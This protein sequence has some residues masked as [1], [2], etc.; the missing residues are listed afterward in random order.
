M[1]LSQSERSG[2]FF[3]PIDSA[4]GTGAGF[5]VLAGGNVEQG[6]MEQ[7]PRSDCLKSYTAIQACCFFCDLAG[8]SN[9]GR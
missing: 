7:E 6:G 1:L 2:C 8:T 9:P 4:T 3:A 5:L